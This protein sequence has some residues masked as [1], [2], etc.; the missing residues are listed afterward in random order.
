MTIDRETEHQIR[1]LYFAE[2]W[3][4]GTIVSALGLHHETVDRVVGPLGPAPKNSEPRPC[5][6]DSYAPFILGVLEKHPKLVGTRV[7]DMLTARGY[8]GSLRTLRRFLNEHRPAYVARSSREVRLCP[9]NSRRWT[10]LTWAGS[11]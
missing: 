3:K 10:G 1:R 2:H 7:Y 5:V 8:S 11:A 9:G 6:L 4:K